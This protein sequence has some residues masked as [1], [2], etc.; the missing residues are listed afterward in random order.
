MY[1]NV[2]IDMGTI[3]IS[4]KDQFIHEYQAWTRALDYLLQENSYL[5]TRLA[6]VVDNNTDKQFVALAEHYHNLF[7]QNDDFIKEML[8]DI[9]VQQEFLKNLTDSHSVAPEKAILKKQVKLRNEMEH[10]ERKFSQMKNEFNQY[11]V[12][13]L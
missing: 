9:R 6:Q 5:K 7:L 2:L 12:S 10:F 11:L 13:H 8:R 1:F 4:G 3:R